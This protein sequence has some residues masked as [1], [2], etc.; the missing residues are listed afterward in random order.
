MPP[1]PHAGFCLTL[2]LAGVRHLPACRLLKCAPALSQPS[3]SE[4]DFFADFLRVSLRFERP[5]RRISLTLGRDQIVLANYLVTSPRVQAYR[6][7]RRDCISNPPRP[8]S[9]P[10]RMTG[11]TSVTDL[12]ATHPPTTRPYALVR[13][14]LRLRWDRRLWACFAGFSSWPVPSP[15]FLNLLWW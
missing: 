3:F 8:L 15:I 10:F 5:G 1:Y 14:A 12:F 2:F 7:P 6:T 4:A 11:I 13:T 9:G